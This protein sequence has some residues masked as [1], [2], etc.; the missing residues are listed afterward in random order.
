MDD[1]VDIGYSGTKTGMSAP[2]HA[3]V[4]KLMELMGSCTLKTNGHH[5]D[6]VGGDA[7]FHAIC[8]ELGLRTVIHLPVKQVLRAF[9]IG[10]EY[11]DPLPYLVRNREIVHSCRIMITAPPTMEELPRGGTWFT[12]RYARKYGVPTFLWI[13]LP[14][15]SIQHSQTPGAGEYLLT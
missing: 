14:D 5:G 4:K 6:C 3:T 7:E 11:R 8:K 10:D 15:G 2:Q 9:C 13:V 12:V 1:F